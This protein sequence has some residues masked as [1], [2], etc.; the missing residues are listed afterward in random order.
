MSGADSLLQVLCVMLKQDPKTAIAYD[1]DKGFC[2]VRL[3]SR[4]LFGADY[5]ED[6]T[7]EKIILDAL[8]DLFASKKPK[9]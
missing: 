8:N 1:K 4:E 3:I 5:W 7:R 9:A 2:W 6:D